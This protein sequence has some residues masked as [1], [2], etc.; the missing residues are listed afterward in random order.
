[1]KVLIYGGGAVGIGL[2]SAL[3]EAGAAVD[4]VARGETATR[5]RR[6]GLSRTGVFGEAHAPVGSFGMMEDLPVNSETVYDHILVCIK[7]YDSEFAA[8]NLHRHGEILD[9]RSNIV[10][11]QNGWGNAEIFAA[12]FEKRNLYN[13]R[14]ITGFQRRALNLV[15]VTVH[16]DAIRIGSIYHRDTA[17]IESLCEAVSQGGIPCKPTG[18]IAGDLWAK[19]LYNCALNALGA[20]FDVPYGELGRSIHTRS[21]MADIVGEV[22]A[23]MEKGGF[24]TTWKMAEDYL[25]TFFDHLIPVTAKHEASTLQDIRAGKR[26]EIDALNGAVVRLGDTYGVEVPVNRTI[27]EMIKFLESRKE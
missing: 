14:I 15:D 22:F 10:L 23:V 7:S 16:V 26:T 18:S 20:V 19:M 27:T 6:E 2:A 4:I 5:L 9:S 21:V 13:A 3:I 24:E 11:C 17:A 12:L 8:Q 1:M 25:S